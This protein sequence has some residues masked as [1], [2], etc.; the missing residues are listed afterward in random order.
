MMGVEVQAEEE[1]VGK[2]LIGLDGEVLRP[3]GKN[4]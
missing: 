1:H 3:P 4:T 2:T